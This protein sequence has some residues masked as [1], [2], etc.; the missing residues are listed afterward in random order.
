ML[1][2]EEGLVVA[3]VAVLGGVVT[4]A[5]VSPTEAADVEVEDRDVEVEASG[6]DVVRE[7]LKV[8]GTIAV[9]GAAAGVRELTVGALVPADPQAAR[10]KQIPS[11]EQAVTTARSE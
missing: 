7:L 3:P 11:D 2:P 9:L 8:A 6:M 10:L 1:L 4:V 5:E